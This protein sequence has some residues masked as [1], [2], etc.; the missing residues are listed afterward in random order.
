MPLDYSPAGNAIAAMWLR[1]VLSIRTCWPGITLHSWYN[2]T[3]SVQNHSM[4]PWISLILKICSRWFKVRLYPLFCTNPWGPRCTLKARMLP[5][6]RPRQ[7]LAVAPWVPSESV[8][9]VCQ[10]ASQWEPSSQCDAGPSYSTSSCPPL[11]VFLSS[12]PILSQ[13][14]GN[15]ACWWPD[16]K[17]DGMIWWQWSKHA[18][19]VVPCRSV[20]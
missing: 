5:I 4:T 6:E 10:S 19:Y 7:A 13:T 12:G 17:S 3:F 18:W 1:P 16:P 9:T 15:G 14:S 20:V 8:V 2:L 11:E